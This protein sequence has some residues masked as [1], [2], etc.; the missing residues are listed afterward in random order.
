[1]STERCSAVTQSCSHTP[2][3]DLLSGNAGNGMLCTVIS[4]VLEIWQLCIASLH[5]HCSI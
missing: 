5:W 4:Q 2:L 3:D 1:M